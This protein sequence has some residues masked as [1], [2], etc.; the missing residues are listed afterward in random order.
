LPISSF[1]VGVLAF[2]QSFFFSQVPV[3]LG[4][5]FISDLIIGVGVLASSE[6]LIISDLFVGVDVLLLWLFNFSFS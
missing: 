2:S 5:W 4:V 3:V 1:K 6:P